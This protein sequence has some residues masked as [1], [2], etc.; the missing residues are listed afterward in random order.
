MS[1]SVERPEATESISSP[2]S[3][4]LRAAVSG[5]LGLTGVAC[6]DDSTTE[7]D[8]DPHEHDMCEPHDDAGTPDAGPHE[9]EE[10]EKELGEAELI[11]LSWEQL[12]AMCDDRDGYIQTH[13]SCSGVNTCQGF[14]YGDWGED[15]ELLEH[16]CS[17]VNGCAG[18]SCVTTAEDGE[19]TGEEI[20]KLED[21]YFI[22]RSGQY[23]A[24]SC[25]TCHTPSEFDDEQG[26]YIYDFTK[27]RLHMWPDS[28]RD[29]TNWTERSA[30]IQE[31]VVMFGAQGMTEDGIHYSNMAPNNKILSKAEIKRVV[32]YMRGFA[33]AD[34]VVE[35]IKLHPGFLEEDAEGH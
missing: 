32:E 14:T 7:G 34:I 25:K 2:S 19:L 8:P 6:G 9:H 11:K 13:A 5:L 28:G 15:A 23:G 17:G 20:M 29:A 12:N 1:K 10:T 30:A 3:A 27:L 31:R 18:L 4:M 33:A 21:S 24:K 22:E 26:A 35:E 16:T